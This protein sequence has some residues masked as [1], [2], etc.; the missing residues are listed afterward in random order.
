VTTQQEDFVT[1][2][3][4]DYELLGDYSKQLPML[5]QYGIKPIEM[6]LD[7]LKGYI[8][9]Y[10]VKDEVLYR[11][12]LHVNARS[13]HY[14]TIAGVTPKPAKNGI[15][16]VYTPLQELIP[17]SGKIVIG[18][19]VVCRWYPDFRRPDDYRTV[20][21]LTF[22]AGNLQMVEDVSVKASLIRAGL[23]KIWDEERQTLYYE[24]DGAELERL[25][26]L[27]VELAT[28]E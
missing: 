23:S 11:T 4:E 20:L 16:V 3:R 27:S 21:R 28:G 1:Y 24:A 14:P 19:D 22:D 8:A 18:K 2:K 7:C 5:Q 26:L 10:T 6:G 12:F 9:H 13:N 17:L 15:G 25:E